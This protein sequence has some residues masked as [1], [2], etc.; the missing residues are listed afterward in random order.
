MSERQRHNVEKDDCLEIVIWALIWQIAQRVNGK[1]TVNH[2]PTRYVREELE[3]R[4][5]NGTRWNVY[6]YKA[7]PK[8]KGLSTPEFVAFENACLFQ[9]LQE[10]CCFLV[11]A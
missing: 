10:C 9:Y 5:D 6:R 7:N 8:T 3:I 2:E 11:A 4:A 1:L